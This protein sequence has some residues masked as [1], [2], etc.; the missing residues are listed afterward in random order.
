[1]KS[2]DI[3]EIPILDHLG[4][5]QGLLTEQHIDDLFDGT[6]LI[7]GGGRG[8]RLMP[9]TE[10]TPK[11]MLQVGGRPIL[12]RILTSAVTQGFQNFVIAINYL[13]DVIESYCGDGSQWGASIKYI[14]EEAPLGTA[15]ALS[16]LG[17]ETVG[18]IIVANGDLI[19]DINYRAM[20]QYHRDSEARISIAV[21]RFEYKNP[22]GVIETSGQYVRSIEE[23]PTIVSQVNTGVYVLDLDT[24]QLINHGQF[25]NM[26]DLVETALG[27]GSKV[28]AFP[29]HEAW[30]DIGT[31]RDLT[32]ANE[33]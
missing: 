12:E 17:S 3:H 33:A 28:A 1:M 27:Q 6:C 23:K 5:V 10:T 31:P 2:K 32:K 20:L 9:F 16:L 14:R 8:T 18:P 19:T 22:Y 26:T 15:G 7:M 24:L 4:R 29:V 11:P 13:G 25:V 30:M 21:R